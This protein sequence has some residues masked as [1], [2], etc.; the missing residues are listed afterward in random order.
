MRMGVIRGLFGTVEIYIRAGYEVAAERPAMGVCPWIMRGLS[1]LLDDYFGSEFGARVTFFN[2]PRV[3]YDDGKILLFLD[4]DQ[5]LLDSDSSPVGGPYYFNG[6]V[7]GNDVSAWQTMLNDLKGMCQAH[8]VELIVQICT[9]KPHGWRDDTVDAVVRFLG[10]LVNCVSHLAE[11]NADVSFLCN[12]N[13][14]AYHLISHQTNEDGTHKAELV[15]SDSNKRIDH[16]PRIPA[17]HSVRHYADANKKYVHIKGSTKGRAMAWVIDRE[18]L[19]V[20]P[21]N[22]I[23]VDDSIGLH[24]EDF[25][26]DWGN[27]DTE[28]FREVDASLLLMNRGLRIG[29]SDIAGKQDSMKVAEHK[30]RA[31]QEALIGKGEIF[32]KIRQV[33]ND[34]LAAIVSERAARASNGLGSKEAF[35]SAV[36]SADH[37]AASSNHFPSNI[38]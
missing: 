12:P 25:F 4:V 3:E 38:P 24:R 15:R 17:I 8:G 18:R 16:D 9:A 26:N 34:R 6:S 7:R 11:R 22:V 37:P 5:M 13:P 19:N 28:K 31:R 10:A 30:R 23:L 36:D 29:Y 33:V 21:R 2:E 20:D 35:F 14:T 1:S 27:A 32:D